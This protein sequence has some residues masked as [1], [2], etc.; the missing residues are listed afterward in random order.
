M[1]GARASA[2]PP[3]FWMKRLPI[4]K[5]P[6]DDIMIGNSNSYILANYVYLLS[7]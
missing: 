2:E 1:P 4:N 5:M 7:I 3:P 6:R